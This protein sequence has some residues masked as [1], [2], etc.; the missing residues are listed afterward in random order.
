M[1]LLIAHHHHHH[2]YSFIRGCHTQPM[3]LYLI[4]S[5]PL[6]I[7]HWSASQLHAQT[8]ALS[9]CKAKS[10]AKMCNGC[11]HTVQKCNILQCYH[12]NLSD[13]CSRP[14]LTQPYNHF[15]IKSA[16][17]VRDKAIIVLFK[18]FRLIWRRTLSFV[19]TWSLYAHARNY[20]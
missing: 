8:C 5:V 10:K 18:C 1:L 12:P 16:L 6:Y 19:H 7:M 9:I 15:K 4:A 20:K 13:F 11:R 17:S 3:L 14:R 2:S